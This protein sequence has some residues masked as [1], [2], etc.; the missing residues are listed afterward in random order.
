MNRLLEKDLKYYR[1]DLMTGNLIYFTHG[2]KIADKDYVTINIKEI[3]FKLEELVESY[4]KILEDNT[5][6]SSDIARLKKEVNTLDLQLATLQNN[7]QIQVPTAPETLKID[8][9]AKDIVT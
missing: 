9:I 4:N 2:Q 5:N 6:L 1:I 8:E 3:V 7:S